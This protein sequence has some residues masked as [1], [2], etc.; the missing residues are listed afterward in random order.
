M[1]HFQWSPN[2]YIILVAPPGIIAKSTSAGVGMELLRDIPGIKFG[3]EVVSWQAL[4]QSMGESAEQ[5]VNPATGEYV[6]MTAVT[7]ES[8]EFGNLL[9]PQNRE[10]VDMF[11]SLWDGKKGA[12]Q[13]LT[14]TQ[15]SDSVINPF[16][17]IIACTTPA[18]I[19][20]NFPEYMI[21]GGFTSRCIFVY[22]EKKFK[23]VAY[24]GLVMPPEIRTSV[25]RQLTEDLQHIASLAGE[26]I[27]SPEAIQWGEHWYQ[28]I[29]EEAPAHL[30]NERFKG[31]IAR[32]Q[33]HLHK[34]AMILSAAESDT[35]V[36]Q[37]SH[38]ELADEYLREIEKD[39]PSV[40]A[41]IGK[42]E[43]SRRAE[44][45]LSII[46]SVSGAPFEIIFR[47][48]FRL[49]PDAGEF[50]D[51]LASLV[52][53]GHITIMASGNTQVVNFNFDRE[54]T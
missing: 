41:H 45:I 14:K 4:M 1:G 12:M 22:A 3:P 30:E 7:I 38:L 50:S 8:S 5:F 2:F 23:Y 35:L 26:Y 31:Y 20:G 19:A 27:L 37:Q 54:G 51:L 36:L 18:W 11:V 46:K 16:I 47:L 43:E 42:T 24:P 17:N 52:R 39:M 15:G 13:K 10:M 33:T 9:D 6:T 25:K 32:K 28:K 34:L 40:F 53:A 44:E 29:Y 21:G 49:M 48:C